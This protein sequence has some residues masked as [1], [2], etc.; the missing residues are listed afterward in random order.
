MYFPGNL[1]IFLVTDGKVKTFTG[2]E[3]FFLH[4]LAGIFPHFRVVIRFDSEL[5]RFA[6]EFHLILLHK[7]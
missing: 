1:I 7:F 5:M 3:S 4:V 2:F 6:I